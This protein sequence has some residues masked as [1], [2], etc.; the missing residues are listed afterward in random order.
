MNSRRPIAVTLIALV[1]IAAGAVGLVYHFGEWRDW[2]VELVRLL[3][4]V[5]GV[6]LLRGQD[7]ARWLALAW[8][9]FH[10]AISFGHSAQQVAIHAVFLLVIGYFLYRP[11]TSLFF[12]PS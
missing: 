10:V 12:K 2:W 3:A 1:Y 6:F 4:I 9:A 5:A 7:W 11:P 8:M